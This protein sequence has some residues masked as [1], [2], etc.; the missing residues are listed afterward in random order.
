MIFT[1]FMI[2]KVDTNC[3]EFIRRDA[4][5]LRLSPT[6]DPTSS[7]MFLKC[8]KFEQAKNGGVLI[9]PQKVFK[10]EFFHVMA[11]AATQISLHIRAI[12]YSLFSLTW[13]ITKSTTS[14]TQILLH[15][16]FFVF[17]LRNPDQVKKNSLYSDGSNML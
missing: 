9:F 15:F 7:S 11:C 16:H 8:I 14:L 13:K 6:S 12:F 17:S 2:E 3:L 5:W 1:I 4:V 10:R